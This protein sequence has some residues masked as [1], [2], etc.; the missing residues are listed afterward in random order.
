MVGEVGGQGWWM[1]MNPFNFNIIKRLE[2]VPADP[3]EI[4]GP[5]KH[6][7]PLLAPDPPGIPS[8]SH[9]DPLVFY[10][11]LWAFLGH[12]NACKSIRLSFPSRAFAKG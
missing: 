1:G 12:A 8:G 9:S 11:F 10:G 4:V 7:S 2:S 5:E 6:G 3:L